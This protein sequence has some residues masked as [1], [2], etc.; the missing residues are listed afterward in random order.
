[1]RLWLVT[2]PDQLTAQRTALG[3][4]PVAAEVIAAAWTEHDRLGRVDP[5]GQHPQRHLADL[6]P[7]AGQAEIDRTLG[8]AVAQRVRHVLAPAMTGGP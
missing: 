1:M 7:P 6:R 4:A 5:V 8:V 2:D 3:L